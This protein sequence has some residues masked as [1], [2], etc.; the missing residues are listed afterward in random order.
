MKS[1][2]RRVCVL[3]TAVVLTVINEQ[4]LSCLR[5]RGWT[6]S[7]TVAVIRCHG[8][9]EYLCEQPPLTI[10]IKMREIINVSA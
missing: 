3:R 9:I 5:F 6:V 2:V 7:F 8:N 10:M 4:S 1:T